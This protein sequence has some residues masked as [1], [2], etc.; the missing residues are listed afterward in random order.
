MAQCAC[1]DNWEGKLH[2]LA[3]EKVAKWFNPMTYVPAVRAFVTPFLLSDGNLINVQREGGLA[4]DRA[5][6]AI[7]AEAHSDAAKENL[8]KQLRSLS[9]IVISAS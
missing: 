6:L 8:A 4:F 3:L 7:V 1:G 5:R 2:D 9:H